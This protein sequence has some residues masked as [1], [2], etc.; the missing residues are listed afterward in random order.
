VYRPGQQ[1]SAQ[2]GNLQ[3]VGGSTGTTYLNQPAALPFQMEAILKDTGEQITLIQTCDWAGH[4]PSFVAVNQDGDPLIASFSET[5]ITDPRVV[6]NPATQQ[7]RN[8]AR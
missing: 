5:R 3:G 8:R 1:S 7:L 2:S 6:P 4:S